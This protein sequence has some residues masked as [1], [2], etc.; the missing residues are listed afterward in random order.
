V[1]SA[2]ECIQWSQCATRHRPDTECTRRADSVHTATRDTTKQSYLSWRCELDNCYSHVHTSDFLSSTVL[3][4]R[5]SSSHC[6][7]GCNAYKTILSCLAWPCELALI[8]DSLGTRE[9]APQTASRFTLFC[10]AH[11]HDQRTYR[12][13]MSVHL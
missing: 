10:G 9:S 3:S 12:Q 13:T 8:C 4:C 11:G 5:E 2:S 6:Q 7:S 1:D